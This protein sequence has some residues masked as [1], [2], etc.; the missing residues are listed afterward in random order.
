MSYTFSMKTAVSIPD[1]VFDEADRLAR[2][3]KTSRSALYARALTEYIARHDTDRV[4]ARMNMA[5]DDIGPDDDG[6]AA[7]A[8]ASTLRNT[9]W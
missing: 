8:A 3:M 2:S 1:E 5:L 9:D 6:F 4:T 7:A